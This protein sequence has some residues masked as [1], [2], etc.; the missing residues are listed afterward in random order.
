M[1]LARSALSLEHALL[2]FLRER[3]MHAYEIHQR[4]LRAEA[5]GLVWRLKQAQLYALLARLEEAGYLAGSLEPQGNR[6]PRKVLR[7]TP[8]GRAALE[9][10]LSEPVEHGRDFRLEFLAKLY[11]AG[12]GG[13]RSTAELIER[14]RKTC[15]DSLRALE[16]RLSALQPRRPYDQLVYEFRIGQLR[17]I[18]AWLDTCEATLAVSDP[19]S[20]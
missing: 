14:Q 10:W 11:F 4:L 6:P 19:P 12:E 2:G 17:A 18:L 16:S 7:L 9:D 1:P 3:P 8:E 15:R 5:L 13:P 20:S